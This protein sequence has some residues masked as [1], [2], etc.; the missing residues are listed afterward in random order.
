LTIKYDSQSMTKW[1]GCAI[2]AL[3]C[4]VIFC[5][6]VFASEQKY[7]V[8]EIT[9]VNTDIYSSDEINQ[10]NIV[11][12][13]FRKTVN[14]LHFDTRERVIRREVI[15]DTGSELTEA[16]LRETERN[17]RSLGYL[18]NVSVTPLDTLPGNVV[19]IEVRYQETWSTN[20]SFSFSVSSDDSRW[21][22]EL[23][24]KNFLGYG[25]LTGLSYSSDE[26]RTT[27]TALF[28]NRRLFGS[29]WQIA[30]QKSMLSDGFVDTAY[31]GKPFHF[32]GDNWGTGCTYWN[33]SYEPRYYLSQT[34]SDNY[35]VTVPIT[36]VGFNLWA[37]KL[38]R[39][40]TQG[41]LWRLGAGFKLRNNKY[42]FPEDSELIYPNAAWR[43][44][45][46]TVV[47]P[48]LL[49][50]SEG[51]SW[52]KSKLVTKYGPIEDLALDPVFSLTVGPS[53]K[54]WGATKDQ[55]ESNFV[56]SNWDGIGEGFVT[57][58]ITFRAGK[59]FSDLQLLAGWFSHYSGNRHSR[60]VVELCRA[61]NLVGNEAYKLG[62]NRG[63]RTLKFDGMTGDRLARWN[64]E[65][66]ILKKNEVMGLARVGFA[67]FVGGGAAWWTEDGSNSF[68]N[69]AGFGLRFG[70]T[71]SANS[72]V[73]RIDLTWDLNNGGEPFI[74]AVTRGLF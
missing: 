45:H 26:E 1:Q 54:L 12:E 2:I 71:R 49:I 72:E 35:Y 23:S 40:F 5:A 14:K 58:Q 68:R 59:D 19:P 21:G 55:W 70:P 7:T 11:L 62:L 48:Y 36:N 47:L 38:V 57:Q 4:Q 41:R 66:A 18:I 39:G 33:M 51:R 22:A 31:M 29:P 24:D 52:G 56:F 44:E 17:L 61:E 69:E 15:P 9:V 65:H 46:G 25:I 74:T 43:R 34:Q 20:I 60:A 30:A 3:L 32:Q 28:N 6:Q 67:G 53:R 63:L 10:A 27:S 42:H 13:S 50:S 16:D 64:V 37:A 73:A 8:G